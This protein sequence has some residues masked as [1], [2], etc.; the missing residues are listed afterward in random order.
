[1]LRSLWTSI[2]LEPDRQV[3]ESYDL[4]PLKQREEELPEC[5]LKKVMNSSW[6]QH[7]DIVCMNELNMVCDFVEILMCRCEMH[8]IFT[9]IYILCNRQ[10]R[11]SS[12]SCPVQIPWTWWRL[13]YTLPETNSKFAPIK[14]RPFAPKRKVVIFQPLTWLSGGG[15]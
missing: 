10:C 3:R 1:M 12:P 13:A 6:Y 4:L 9:N 15:C 14:N 8:D 7:S 5:T 11:A 2:P